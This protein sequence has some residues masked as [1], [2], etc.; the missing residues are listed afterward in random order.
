ME[1]FCRT[2]VH[3][4]S[5][6]VDTISMMD[7][8]PQADRRALSRSVA[9][10][11]NALRTGPVQRFLL[12]F[13]SIESLA[14][15]IESSKKKQ[16]S[17]LQSEF[18]ADKPA[19]SERERIR[20]S[21]IEDVFASGSVLAKTVHK[22][23]HDCIYESIREKLEDHLDRVF[24]SDE[25]SRIMFKDKVDGKTL[26]RLRHDVAHGN[27]NVLSEAETRFLSRR[28]G[29]L[30]NIARSYLRKIFTTLAKADYFARPRRPVLTIPLSQA[31]GS[32]GTEYEGPT[33]MAEYYAN[34][35]ALSA[36][37]VRVKF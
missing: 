3:S 23:Y 20:D 35:E 4:D 2:N 15:Y 8:L 10:I 25:V 26:W 16:N 5:L 32:P 27:L 29:V 24:K 18:A 13:V 19:Q 1:R 36:S 17:I 12:L 28:V 31:I 7:S 9:W 37:Y 33:D 21:C 34:V 22:A 14:T 6:L 11:A 30:E